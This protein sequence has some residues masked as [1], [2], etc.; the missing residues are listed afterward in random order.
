VPGRL[1][2][3]QRQA[4]VHAAA[5]QQRHAQPRAARLAPGPRGTR[6]SDRPERARA[7]PP[8]HAQTL[9]SASRTERAHPASVPCCRHAS[10]TAPK[11]ACMGGAAPPG[12][13]R[14]SCWAVQSCRLSGCASLRTSS[15]AATALAARARGVAQPGGRH[16]RDRPGQRTGSLHM[17]ASA[18]SGNVCPRRGMV[19]GLVPRLFHGA[20]CF[21]VRVTTSAICECC[22]L[23]QAAKDARS[24]THVLASKVVRQ[25]F[26]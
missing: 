23:V 16:G 10:A 8:A 26:T 19:R 4:A 11:S 3:A 7:R 18:C 24:T 5:Q 14:R 22:L 1:Q 6:A 21:C 15:A 13:S 17:P 25:L 2:Q 20:T 9:A 12:S